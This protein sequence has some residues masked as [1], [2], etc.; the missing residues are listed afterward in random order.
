MVRYEALSNAFLL[1]QLLSY[2]Y[3]YLP[4]PLL[5]DSR[6]ID[7]YNHIVKVIIATTC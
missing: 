7:F 2:K 5:L 3:L 4:Q 6:K 1:A